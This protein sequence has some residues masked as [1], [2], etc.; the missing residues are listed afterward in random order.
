MS[1]CKE[2]GRNVKRLRKQAGLSQE[3]LAFEAGISNSYLRRVEHGTANPTVHELEKVAGALDVALID[4][5]MVLG[6]AGAA[7]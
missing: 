3:Q 2:I 1:N 7:L 4:L 6:P 5:V